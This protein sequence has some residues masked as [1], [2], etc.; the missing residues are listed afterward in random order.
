MY[1]V[2]RCSSQPAS[3]KHA[4]PAQPIFAFIFSRAK[5]SCTA[6]ARGLRRSCPGLVVCHALCRLLG[7]SSRQP[8]ASL[9]P[10]HSFTPLHPLLRR[11]VSFRALISAAFGPP[12][13]LFCCARLRSLWAGTCCFY[14][15]QKRTF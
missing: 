4:T 10:L 9:K 5:I 11:R 13:A 2:K 15:C 7:C 3:I 12:A 1:Q 14:C 8:S 6:R